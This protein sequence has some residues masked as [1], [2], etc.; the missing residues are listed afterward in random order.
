MAKYIIGML[1]TPGTSLK[2]YISLLFG[3]FYRFSSEYPAIAIEIF[4]T[5]PTHYLAFYLAYRGKNIFIS[6]MLCDGLQSAI[7]LFQTRVVWVV[8]N[9]QWPF[10]AFFLERL[11]DHIITACLGWLVCSLIV[12][13][14][15]SK[16]AVA[17]EKGHVDE[18]V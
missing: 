7:L 6:A 2:E 16:V 12:K 1:Y 17:K 3:I 4:F 10:I 14:R 18:R 5:Q 11:P 9:R 13:Y 8:E 15:T